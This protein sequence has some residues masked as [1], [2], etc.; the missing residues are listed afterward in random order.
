MEKLLVEIDWHEL[1]PQ[2][3]CYLKKYGFWG[4]LLQFWLIFGGAGDLTKM[5]VSLAL[6]H[7][8][9][10]NLKRFSTSKMLHQ[11]Y[12]GSEI[13]WLLTLEFG[14]SKVRLLK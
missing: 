9:L 11:V 5:P 14:I 8:T 12:H 7:Q 1:S 13:D 10:Q 2:F 3:V 4:V 6:L